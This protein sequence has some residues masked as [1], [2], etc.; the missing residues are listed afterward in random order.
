[1]SNYTVI[2]YKP[3]YFENCLDIAT[4][5]TPKY[6][7]PSELI[8]YRKFLEEKKLYFVLMKKSKI[9]ACG[10]YAFNKLKNIVG[11]T[12]GLVHKE[13][14]RQGI[15]SFLLE[16]RIS[17]IRDKYPKSIIILDTSQHTHKF[18]KKYGFNTTNIIKHGYGK[19]LH[20]HKMQLRLC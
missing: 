6:I 3:K 8:L 1:M 9:I 18:Y 5:N 19:N 10:G 13:Y 14:H 12:W 17:E 2:N 15:G 4:S 20:K 16:Y 7:D 11:L